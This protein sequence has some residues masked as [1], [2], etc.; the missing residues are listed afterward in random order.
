[1]KSF[2]QVFGGNWTEQKL[3]CVSKYLNAYTT[4]MDKQ[5]FNFAYVDAFAGTGYRKL[6]LEEDPNE[7]LFPELIS[8]DILKFRQG[9]ARNALEVQPRFQKYFFIEQKVKRD[10]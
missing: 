5:V 10:I 9:S 8:Q 7:T 3:D 4:I 6:K 2:A 1:M